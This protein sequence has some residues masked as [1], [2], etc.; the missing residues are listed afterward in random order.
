MIESPQA[1]GNRLVSL[2]DSDAA[3]LGRTSPL[4]GP[5]FAAARAS[6]SV[7]VFATLAGVDAY[8]PHFRSVPDDSVLG[9]AWHGT[10]RERGRELLPGAERLGAFE[11]DARAYGAE[12]RVCWPS[13]SGR[14]NP[15]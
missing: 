1:A 3:F 9:R 10:R 11:V 2:A 8:L 12:R 7:C 14:N 15:A 4:T 13:P 6:P 5:R